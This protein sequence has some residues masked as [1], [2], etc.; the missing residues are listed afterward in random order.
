[1]SVSF[2]Q[3][4]RWIREHHPEVELP[5]EGTP[6]YERQNEEY[7]NGIAQM[8]EGLNYVVG[9]EFT[10]EEQDYYVSL[11]SDEEA[12]QWLSNHRSTHRAKNHKNTSR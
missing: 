6:E 3:M 1:M 5:E 9:D 12:E 11:P 7:D 10:K 2:K 4:N 8:W